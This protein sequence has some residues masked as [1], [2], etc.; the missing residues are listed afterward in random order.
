M[1]APTFARKLNN[2]V[3]DMSKVVDPSWRIVGQHI[4]GRPV[5]ESM[6]RRWTNVPDIDPST[7][8][9]RFQPNPINGLP[10]YLRRRLDIREE[11]YQFVL[12]DPGNGNVRREPYVAPSPEEVRERDLAR[13]KHDL[14]ANLIHGL[15]ERN[16]DVTDLLDRLAPPENAASA[17]EPVVKYPRYL[18]VGRWGLSD[19]TEMKC[20]REEAEAAEAALHN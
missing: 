12:Y 10:S 9:Q 8:E 2:I 19:G 20:S 15:A 3:A 13:R 11:P 1:A 7:G 4:D 5:Y 16:M 14:M 18:P 17:Q 6:E